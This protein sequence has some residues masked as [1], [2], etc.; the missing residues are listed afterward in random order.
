MEGFHLATKVVDLVGQEDLNV[1]PGLH[2]VV[3]GVHR[4]EA[5]WYLAKS[6]SFICRPSLR[7]DVTEARL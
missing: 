1:L 5:L 4:I 3:G 2:V 6:F 7:Y